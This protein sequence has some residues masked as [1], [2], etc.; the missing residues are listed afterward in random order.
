[1][2]LEKNTKNIIDAIRK[3]PS[4]VPVQNII[5]NVSNVQDVFEKIKNFKLGAS[6]KCGKGFS[7]I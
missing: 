6:C 2:K 4:N 7:Y 3:K 1:L 5:D